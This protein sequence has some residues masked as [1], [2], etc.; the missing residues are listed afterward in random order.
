MTLTKLDASL[1]YRAEVLV[2]LAR[3][4][5]FQGEYELARD[6]LLRLIKL[7]ERVHGPDNILVALT[8][9]QLGSGRLN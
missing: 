2:D 1:H 9:L 5:S 3:C 4:Y 6:A 7:E 8:T